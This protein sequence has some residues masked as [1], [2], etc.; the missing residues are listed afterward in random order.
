MLLL[1][2][3][4]GIRA[5]VHVLRV[6]QHILAVIVS[7]LCVIGAFAIRNSFVDLYVMIGIGVLGYFLMRARI[8]VTPII[9]GLV[10]GPTLEGE[11]RTALILSDGDLS[12]FWQSIP[13]LL[14]FGLTALIIVFQFISSARARPT[15]RKTEELDAGQT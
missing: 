1:F 10:L 11:F 6:P 2:Q 4:F 12:T 14:F 3:Y 13:A 7:V 15:L 5:F 8:P 9:L